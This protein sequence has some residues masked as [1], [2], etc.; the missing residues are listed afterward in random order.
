MSEKASFEENDI[1]NLISKDIKL[2]WWRE[3]DRQKV[4]YFSD[5]IKELTGLHADRISHED[6]IGMV[7]E[8]Y[9]DRV[10]MEFENKDIYNLFDQVFPMNC[11]NGVL[12]MHAKTVDVSTDDAGI[13][14][15]T[16]Y[17][18][19]ID[20][21]EVT[22]PHKASAMRINN[23]LY[24]LNNI[25]QI[26]LSFLQT[27]KSET[28]IN[29][30]LKDMLKQFKAGRAYIIEY[31]WLKRMQTCTYEVVSENVEPQID[32]INQL[33]IDMNSW[34]TTEIMSGKAIIL[35]TLDDLPAEASE[36]KKFLAFQ[37]I[38]SL[39]VVPLFAKNGVW[40]YAGIDIVEE[41]HS[42]VKED[43]EWLTALFNIISLCV[44][45]QRSEQKAQVDKRYLQNLYKNMPLGYL[46]VKVLHNE[47]GKPADYLFIDANPAAEELFQRPLISYIGH[48]ASVTGVDLEK[49]LQYLCMAF[50]ND[51]YVETDFYIEKSDKYTRLVMYSIQQD[52]IVCLFSDITESHKTARKLIKA[53]EKAEVSDRLKSAFLANMSHEI[54]TPLNAIVGFSDLLVEVEDKEERKTY[55]DIVHKNNE[56]LLQLISDILDLSK[57]ESGTLEVV[58]S[59]VKVNKLLREMIKYY[60][61]KTEGTRVEVVFEECMPS[62]IIYSDKNRITQIL[63]NFINNALKFTVEGSISV[64]YKLVGKD[65]IKFYVKDTGSGIA[66][67]DLDKIFARFVKLDNFVAGA[68]LG[69]SIS[70]SLVKQMDGEIGVESELG[71]GSCF[72]FTHPYDPELQYNTDD[73]MQIE[74]PQIE[75]YTQKPHTPLILVAEDTESNYMLLTSIMRDK[76]TLIRAMNGAE[77]IQLYKSIK[78]DLILMDIKMPVMDGI[79]ATKEIRKLDQEIPIV[80]VTAFA[81]DSDKQKALE[82]G[83]TD[84]MPKPIKASVLLKKIEDILS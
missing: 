60:R 15:A 12:W 23:L 63:S 14:H 73:N 71:V 62:C 26:L 27:D 9:R 2:G 56:L 65:K 83:C 22:A 54:R 33:S 41:Y 31:D 4:F 25:S 42:W 6:F 29:N 36:E 74:I 39:F 37:D 3:N 77:A 7:R 49:N 78:P 55:S 16:G 50:Y 20:N 58:Y 81:F 79:E 69:L 18:Q 80:A 21:P 47:E 82:A 13:V 64:G 8:D 17:I 44:Q 32:L 43:A 76:Y 68:G 75:N 53:K 35:S 30:I 61:L 66:K 40:G 19:I 57:I 59:T 48:K 67:E 11:P 5:L 34:W 46:R 52:E 10:L 45:L 38:K 72:W 28:A 84:Y 70:K 1:L 51:G 24:Q